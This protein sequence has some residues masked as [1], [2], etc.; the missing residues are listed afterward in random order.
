MKLA[1]IITESGD[2]RPK[3]KCNLCGKVHRSRG[4]GICYPCTQLPAWKQKQMA[5]NRKA[6]KTKRNIWAVSG[7]LPSLGKRR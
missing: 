2:P 4:N 1:D 7:G 3:I 5:D 6:S